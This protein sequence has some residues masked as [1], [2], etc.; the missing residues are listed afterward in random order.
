[1]YKFELLLKSGH[2]LTWTCKKKKRAKEVQESL[3]KLLKYPRREL[4]A[5]GKKKTQIRFQAADLV[6]FSSKVLNTESKFQAT[7][8][9]VNSGGSLNREGLTDIVAKIAKGISSH[10]AVIKAN[11]NHEPESR[12]AVGNVKYE[13]GTEQTVKNEEATQQ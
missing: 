4:L 1:M 7:N 6:A 3:E 8:V 11:E 5:L 2:T 9:K 10:P 12:P 13:G